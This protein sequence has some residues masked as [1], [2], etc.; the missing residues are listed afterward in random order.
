[1]GI[2][3]AEEPMIADRLASGHL[4][5]VHSARVTSGRGYFLLEPKERARKPIVDAFVNWI[6]EEMAQTEA[7]IENRRVLGTSVRRYLG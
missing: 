5:E 6:F 4:V 1:M 3:M 7:T 2:V